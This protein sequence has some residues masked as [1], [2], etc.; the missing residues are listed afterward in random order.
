MQPEGSAKLEN[1]EKYVYVDPIKRMLNAILD[2]DAGRKVHNVGRVLDAKAKAADRLEKNWSEFER[3]YKIALLWFIDSIVL[4]GDDLERAI[5]QVEEA[6]GEA[7]EGQPDPT[8]IIK[9]LNHEIRGKYAEHKKMGTLS[10]F[11]PIAR[12]AVVDFTALPRN[13]EPNNE[14]SAYR[15]ILND[16]IMRQYIW[17]QTLKEE[18]GE[19]AALIV[20]NSL[21]SVKDFNFPSKMN[22]ASEKIS[23]LIRAQV[24]GVVG[25]DKLLTDFRIKVG[26]MAEQ[27][28]RSEETPQRSG[29]S[30]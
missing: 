23:K 5:T 28:S 4:K 7:H 12:Q 21:L 25:M 18:V 2:A 13:G 22:E 24:S 27:L 16:E 15:V 20:E 6:V 29:Y 1:E 26:A 8:E 14:A 10:D 9:A 17:L 11:L 19:Y 30:R 3:R